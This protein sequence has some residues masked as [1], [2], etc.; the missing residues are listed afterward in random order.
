MHERLG[1]A[2]SG[3]I[4][5]G[6]AAAAARHG[7]VVM[8]ARSDSSAQR[9]RGS[10]HTI[11]GRLSGEINAA[12]VRVETDLD[13]L[14]Q[15]TAVIEAVCEDEAIKAGVLGDLGRVAGDGALLASTTSSL[16]VERLTG[17]SGAAEGVHVGL[18]VYVSG[19]DLPA[20]A[21]ADGVD[22]APR[23]LRRA[24]GARPHHDLAVARGRRR[25]AARDGAAARYAESFL[26]AAAAP[27]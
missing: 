24:V 19:V 6:L 4:A 12:H 13:A 11:R 7:E 16:S 15:A 21:P 18:H 27:G 10:I 25:E 26:H 17:A 23:P 1:I 2:G 5:C 22:A 9:A 8:W 3:A 14:C 20:Q